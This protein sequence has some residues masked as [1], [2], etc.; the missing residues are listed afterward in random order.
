MAAEGPQAPRCPASSRDILSVAFS[1][2]PHAHSPGP[3]ATARAQLRRGPT[4]PSP[5]LQILS[6]ASQSR[7]SGEI[8]R[9]GGL[10]A[11][12]RSGL[13]SDGPEIAKGWATPQPSGAHRSAAPFL[14]HQVRMKAHARLCR[15]ACIAA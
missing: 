7:R 3:A 4:A 1:R 5:L 15:G 8:V 6:A 2:D 14:V 9:F 12:S 10:T 11:F 13:S